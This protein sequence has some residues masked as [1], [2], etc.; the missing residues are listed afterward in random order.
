MAGCEVTQTGMETQND[1]GAHFQA[2]TRAPGTRPTDPRPKLACRCLFA[3]VVKGVDLRST[4]G[5]SAGVRIP[6]RALLTKIAFSRETSP[7]FGPFWACLH[8]P[9]RTRPR[10]PSQAPVSCLGAGPHFRGRGA[11]QPAF[12]GPGARRPSFLDPGAGRPS[13]LDPGA[14]KKRNLSA[15]LVSPRRSTF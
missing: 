2:R 7:N 5:T 4:G 15:H 13:F 12:S 1:H 6:E 8:L 3:Q 9:L 14:S 10:P 11:R